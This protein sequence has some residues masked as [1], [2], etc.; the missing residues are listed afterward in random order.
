MRK[1]RPRRPFTGTEKAALLVV[2]IQVIAIVLF[3]VVVNIND[4]ITFW[5]ST[6][7]NRVVWVYLAPISLALGYWQAR[8]FQKGIEE[9]WNVSYSTSEILLIAGWSYLVF[10]LTADSTLAPIYMS[11]VTEP[12]IR[13]VEVRSTS[14]ARV[15]MFH[16]SCGPKKIRH[17]YAEYARVE[18]DRVERLICVEAGVR[19]GEKIE[20]RGR[21]GPTGYI[22]DDYRRL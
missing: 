4:S 1:R 11:Y 7:L 12:D 8:T 10:S 15:S 5:P 17:Y 3:L 20:L 18:F 19:V 6:S 13:V 2:F 21:I 22:V 9:R 14:R 16:D